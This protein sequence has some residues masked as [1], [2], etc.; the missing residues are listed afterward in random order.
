MDSEHRHELEENEL[1]GWLTEKVQWVQAKLPQ[2]VVSIIALIA[3]IAGWSAYSN[4]AEAKRAESW[5]SYSLAVGG[6]NPSLEALQ[7]A[8]TENPGTE[9]ET[10]S[11]ITWA[12]GQLFNGANYYLRDRIKSEEALTE[13]ETAYKE[14]VSAKNTEIADRAA[15]GLAR[16]LD[17]RGDLDAARE[18]YARVGGPFAELAADRAEEL[19]SE[20]VIASY[21]WI[22]QTSA[23]PTDTA[24][25]DRP[26]LTPDAIDLP[27]DE[28]TEDPD[29]TL[30]ALL[31]DIATDAAE[32]TVE[33]ITEEAGEEAAPDQE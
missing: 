13:A 21:A 19:A 32:E 28:E 16:I 8:A 31:E 12:D 27:A 9:V 4:N 24:T 17:L 5:R 14:L 25:G 23:A 30:D 6:V 15:Y 3:A 2:I 7:L 1:A 18:Q 10:W 33:E 11:R 29:A 26:D 20:K 22:T